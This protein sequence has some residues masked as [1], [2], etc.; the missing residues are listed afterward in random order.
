VL[1]KITAF[2]ET[3]DIPVI[4]QPKTPQALP[5]FENPQLSIPLNTIPPIPIFL[6]QGRFAMLQMPDDA[7]EDDFK[8]AGKIIEAYAS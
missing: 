6:G 7:T 5:R 2:E 3:S 1:Y 8:K 4:D